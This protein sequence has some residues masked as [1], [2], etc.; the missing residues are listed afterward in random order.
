MTRIYVAIGQKASSIKNVVRALEQAGRW[1]TPLSWLPHGN[2]RHATCPPTSAR[3]WW[4][5]LRDR[6][7]DALIV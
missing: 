1:N 2:R 5:I 6:G 3:T 4:R 7:Q